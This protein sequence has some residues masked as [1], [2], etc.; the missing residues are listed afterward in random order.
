[1]PQLTL[2]RPGHAALGRWLTPT[3]RD[4]IRLATDPAFRRRLAQLRQTGGCERPIHLTGHTTWFAPN[5]SILR[6]YTTKGEPAERIAVRCGTRRASRCEPCSRL[7]A[8]DTYQLVRA[9][10]AGGK[11]IPAPAGHPML[12]VTL[13]APSFGAVHRSGRCRPQHQTTCDHGRPTG[14]GQHHAE[15][16]PEVGQ[17]LCAAC[18]D[19]NHH[20]LW[21]AHVGELW[22][23]TVRIVRRRLATAADIPRSRLGDHLQVAFAKVAEYQRRGA[24]HLHFVM[25][26]DGPEGPES[27]PPSWATEEL[28]ASSVNSASVTANV[29]SPDCASVG[30][31]VIRWGEQV[32]IRPI[33]SGPKEIDREAVA[34]YLA[35]YVTKS[36]SE[37]GDHPVKSMADLASRPMPGHTRVLMRTCWRLGGLREFCHLKLR[38]WVHTMGFRG[39]VL[40]KSRAYSTTYRQLRENRARHVGGYYP[41]GV[42]IEKEWR[43]AGAGLSLAEAEIAS[44]IRHDVATRRDILREVDPTLG[45]RRHARQ[46]PAQAPRYRSPEKERG[47]DRC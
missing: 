25:R 26:L 4:F 22:S 10:L 12:F 41:E 6:H 35:K 42:R 46:R 39:H 17:P 45:I 47:P 44:G 33:H 21:H 18:Y 31:L 38:T 36:S 8:G 23:R 2:Q 15:T 37:G 5:G 30:E 20:V 7:H 34:S 11:G 3:E 14:C 29:R 40:T 9:G 16:A 27:L 24:I 19:Y 28:L 13:T 43:Y 1:M 32:D